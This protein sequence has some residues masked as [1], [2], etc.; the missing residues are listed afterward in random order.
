M[1]LQ[2]R[3]H[4]SLNPRSAEARS[5]LE[6]RRRYTRRIDLVGLRVAKPGL[7]QEGSFPSCS[8]AAMAAEP[9]NKTL[10]PAAQSWVF[11]AA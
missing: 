1:A 11:H 2:V 3:R 6:N 5:S 7:R 4:G 10:P 9:L 8:D